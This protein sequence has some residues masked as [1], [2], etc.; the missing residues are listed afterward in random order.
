M[1]S[2]YSL[3]IVLGPIVLGAVLLW[4]VVT[5]RRSRRQ[6]QH[7]ETATRRMYDQQ[8]RDD[9]SGESHRT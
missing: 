1:P 8:D 6:E 5:N 9:K 7:S 2:I 3:M 4:A